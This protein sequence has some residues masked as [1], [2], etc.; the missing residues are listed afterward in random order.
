MNLCSILLYG[1]KTN[2]KNIIGVLSLLLFILVLPKTA[3]SV[4]I[5]RIKP[6]STVVELKLGKKT[7]F[8][9]KGQVSG[10]PG[11][12][13][14]IVFSVESLPDES[15]PKEYP[16]VD[17]KEEDGCAILCA[18]HEHKVKYTWNTVGSYLVTATVYSKNQAIAPASLTWTVN[19]VIPPPEITKVV[20]NLEYNESKGTDPLS[21]VTY[22]VLNTVDTW[23]TQEG[24]DTT[25]KI[26]AKSE[27]KI[28]YIEFNSLGKDT[29][30][31]GWGASL[32]NPSRT[33]S[34]K[35]SWDRGGNKTVTATIETKAGGRAVFTWNIFVV[36]RNR[37]PT[38]KKNQAPIRLP[39]LTVGSLAQALDMSEYFSD[40]DGDIL[41]YNAEIGQNS[42]V[43]DLRL[44]NTS[45]NRV[46]ILPVQPWR[47][48]DYRLAITP[49]NAGSATFTIT[50]SDGEYSVAQ[51]FSVVVRTPTL[52]VENQVPG[53]INSI[54]TQTLRMGDSSVTIDVSSY[55]R[56]PDADVL[57]YTVTSSD[58]NV[59]SVQRTGTSSITI[60]PTG[61]GNAQVTVTA[62]D[63]QLTATQT[64]DVSVSQLI[65]TNPPRAM[66]S[67]PSQSLTDD[68][69]AIT[70]DVANNF[71]S[72]NNLTY[73][74][75][76][77][78]SGIVTTSVSGSRVTI[79]PVSAGITTVVVTARDTVNT[80][81]TAVQ[82]I[83][84]SVAQSGAVIVRPPPNTDPTF[85]VPDRSNPRAE[86]LREGVSVIVQLDDPDTLPL[87]V[88]SGPGLSYDILEEI[89]NITGI[90]TDGPR[91][92]DGY[93]WWKIEWDPVNLEGWSVESDRGQIL[94][95]RPPD[96]RI[97]DFDV[98]DD[99]VSPG[100]RIE[101][102]VEIRNNGPGESAA[103]DVSFYYHSGSRNDNLEELDE[104]RNL[105][106]AGTLPVPSLRERG[107][108]TLTLSVDAPTTPDRY[109]YG[110]FLPNNIHDTDY[111]GDLTESMIRNNLARE[112]R[113]EVTGAPDYI[114]ESISVSNPT[115]DPGQ[116]FTLRTTVR[117][118]GLGKPTSS[119][120][121]A[122]YRSPDARISRSDTKVGGRSV[123]RLDTGKTDTESIKLTAPT[124]PGVYYYGACLSKVTNE[125]N[126]N[127]NCSAA[128]AI[129]VRANL[130]P[131]AVGTIPAQTLN[132]GDS[133][134][135]IDISSNFHDP[136][137][138]NLTYAASSSNA[139]IANAR[140]SGSQ[141]T[142]TP[143][144][145]GDA[146]IT[147]TAS[148]GKLT[149][150]QTVSVSVVQQNRGPV[151]VGTISHQTLKIGD[152][153]VVLD[154]SNN[155]QD[156]DGGNLTY[157]AS[158][159]NTSVADVDVSGSQ[160][161][162]TPVSEGDSTITVTASDG[163]L[164]ATQTFS[165]TVT[166]VSHANQTP[167]TIG[168]ISDRT[169]AVEDS[170]VVLEVSHNFS[171]PDNDT[172]T[173]SVF[174]DNADVVNAGVSGSQVTITPVGAGSA[175][176]TVG[177]SDGEFT[178]THT[179]S[180]TVTA[181]PV[182]NRA[183]VTVGAISARTLAVG[184]SPIVLDVA[185]N[186]NDPDG[187]TLTYRTSSDN[188]SVAT[189]N[190]VGSQVTI[191]PVGKGSATITIT[192]SDGKL[193]ATQTI[194][195]TVTVPVANRAPVAVGTISAR[196][197]TVGD[198]AV[199][200]DVSGNFNDPDKDDLTY[201]VSSNNTRV[202]TSSASSS[203]ITITPVGA[204]SAT[205]TIT[206]S[207]GKLSGT[208]TLSIS[209]NAPASD[210]NWMP[211]GN[212]TAAVRAALGL[213]E[214]EE[215]TQE[216]LKRLTSLDA[217][218][219]QISDLTGLEY[220]TKL[221]S[222]GLGVNSISDISAVS[223][224]TSLTTLW[225]PANSISDISALS[226]LT[227]FTSLTLGANSISDISA[228]SGL[229][230]LTWLTLG[231]TSISDISAI[232][233]LTSLT[234][235]DLSGNSISDISAVSGLTSLTSLHLNGNSI[236]DISA[237]SG[238]KNLTTLSIS[239]NP[240]KDYGPLRSL[241]AA[242]EADGR[243]LSL[244]ITIPAAAPARSTAP[245]K[246]ALLPNYPNPFNPETWIPYQL[247][248]SA[249]VTLTIYNMRGVVVRQLVL[250]HRAAGVY[251][252]RS[253]AVHWDGKNNI[254]EKVA[255]GVYFV[256]FRAGDFTATRKMLIRK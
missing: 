191:T 159:S 229:T 56:D 213:Q 74:A 82:T 160:V 212:L 103:T 141:V 85:D 198:A 16:Q 175:S 166:A 90:I 117:N 46:E 15:P 199:V 26:T 34:T 62:S 218:A 44:H 251:Y 223:G 239:G 95:R 118:Q 219:S 180:V 75:S 108:T 10:V 14:K 133:P 184:S 23:R 138:D 131:V 224:L 7:E 48:S 150:T 130:A 243:S 49:Q 54:S 195:V 52:P 189:A 158:S 230:S 91:Q 112:E 216:A 28:A 9:V 66:G 96:L 132:I 247:A 185:N 209:V 70:V 35:Y 134:L 211:D 208:Q 65:V 249:D 21:G 120:W 190:P 97:R 154:V 167:I 255:T 69:A 147:V 36:Q 194:S 8:K 24:T 51:T 22:L 245:T 177:A 18:S 33:H 182:A 246:T 248:K 207:D 232:S 179:I 99:E 178:A 170:P 201:S 72:D 220:A 139:S 109:F 19:V 202:V 93:T 217:S 240:I 30:R 136:D 169:L 100:Q 153:V 71:S 205:I 144:I 238:L 31:K 38:L 111:R 151:A 50:A 42:D 92:A 89:G 86:G 152:S 222:L 101:L 123:S 164:T 163:T 193:T 161:T 25:F 63:G 2:V 196:T 79:T 20:P 162:I 113:V 129:T 41:T 53:P 204:G 12:I 29:D 57:S 143:V 215:L 121:L 105:R 203:K 183:P 68:G 149:A 173:Y 94:Y 47:E 87:R 176:I 104:E 171:D 128:V 13:D 181:T 145:E 148:D 126:S 37:P 228:V 27:D 137:G 17:G 256:K 231:A 192:A 241:I 168:V 76:T 39:A 235:L 206:A 210:V 59:V 67:I 119:A 77:N 6:T 1:W 124:E 236:S 40:P 107:S 88:R 80:D 242:I 127:N 122:Y 3:S 146:I 61:V 106:S 125:S 115:L 58:V 252:N 11:P 165:V 253:R 221:T 55:F 5:E 102:E 172:L 98:S 60:S 81:L 254:G 227:S 225:L 234:T 116:E 214:G 186:F 156:P 155:F 226:G 237:V 32:L 110:A 78:P 197:L 135:Q 188:N 142:I 157:S 174:S 4:T 43:I 140:V 73:T 233:G 250:G 200:I 64:F 84:V 83:S 187:D 114:V 244:D 45:T